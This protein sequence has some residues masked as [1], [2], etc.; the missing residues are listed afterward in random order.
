LTV[1]LPTSQA[2]APLLRVQEDFASDP[3]ARDWQI[4]G[5]GSLFH[6]EAE[7]G[8]LAVTWD[9]AM[10]N[11]YCYLPLGTFLTSDDDFRLEFTLTLDDIA[12]GTTTGKPW[13]FQ[14]ALGFINVAQA[15]S[16][17]F[18]RGTGV[19]SPNLVEWDY[20]PDSG[21]GATVAAAMVSETN[22][23]ATSFNVLQPEDDLHPGGAYGFVLNYRAATHELGVEMVVGEQK[24]PLQSARIREPFGD[25][26]VDALAISSYS[27]AGQDPGWSGSVLAHGRIDRIV[28]DLPPPPVRRFGGGF[29][30]GA[31]RAEFTGWLGWEYTLEVSPNLRAWSAV[32]GPSHGTGRRQALVDP[33]PAPDRAFYRIRANR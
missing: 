18:V 4:A 10:P 8:H 32:D 21:F 7:T 1:A 24:L 14:I 25:Y 22:A 33:Q 15:T 20:F 12:V 11:S 26:A 29:V 27:D 31:W 17:P 5:E 23:W 30:D 16:I 6:W 9:S 19:D 13:T 28:L 2:A 3:F